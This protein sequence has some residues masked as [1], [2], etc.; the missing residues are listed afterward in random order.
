[1]ENIT[2]VKFKKKLI[3]F[4]EKEYNQAVKVSREKLA[5]LMEAIGWASKHISVDDIEAFAKDMVGYFAIRLAD[6]KPEL[7]KLGVTNPVK[8]AEL[9]DININELQTLSNRFNNA[10]GRIKFKN[11]KV[12]EDVNPEDFKIYTKDEQ[13]NKELEYAEKIIKVLLEAEEVTNI[14]KRFIAQV[15]GGLVYFNPFD[16]GELKYN[17]QHI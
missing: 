3:S 17:H 1:M 8:I 7:L 13:Q 14:N 9:L 12:Q 16:G 6:S 2:D 4:S 15:T 10:D 5:K 11:G